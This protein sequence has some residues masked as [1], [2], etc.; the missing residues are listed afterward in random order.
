MLSREDVKFVNS[1]FWFFSWSPSPA[2][3]NASALC[4]AVNWAAVD[5]YLFEHMPVHIRHTQLLRFC[6]SEVQER[7]KSQSHNCTNK[8]PV[9]NFTQRETELHCEIKRDKK[10]VHVFMNFQR[11]TPTCQS[12]SVLVDM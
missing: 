2:E 9:T 6:S 12:K 10:T 3:G 1:F 11:M 7:E 5:R 4:L 8:Q